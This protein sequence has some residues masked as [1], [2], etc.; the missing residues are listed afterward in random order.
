MKRPQPTRLDYVIAAHVLEA[1]PWLHL[2]DARYAPGS[3]VV[4]VGEFMRRR[5]ARL[6]RAAERVN[7][8][9]VAR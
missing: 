7:R 2:T 1:S 9:E 6:R 3:V 8:I 5:A 4:W